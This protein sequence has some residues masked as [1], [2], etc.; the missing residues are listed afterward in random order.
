MRGSE[1]E[2]G[3]KKERVAVSEIKRLMSYGYR[4]LLI[5]AV[6]VLP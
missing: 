5:A 2:G 1:R 6:L 4:K 3:K